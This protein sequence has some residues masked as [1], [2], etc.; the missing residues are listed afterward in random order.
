MASS[1]VKLTLQFM[2]NFEIA[3]IGNRAVGIQQYTISLKKNNKK[4]TDQSKTWRTS[5]KSSQLVLLAS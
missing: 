1:A 4:L 5:E 2:L 3:T